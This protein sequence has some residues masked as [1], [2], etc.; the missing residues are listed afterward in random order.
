[1][2]TV[3]G[4]RLLRVKCKIPMLASVSDDQFIVLRGLLSDN[5]KDIMASPSN[6]QALN[7][8]AVSALMD[9]RLHHPKFVQHCFEA[10]YIPVCNVDC[11]RGFSA[12]GDIL[13]PNRN[14][15]STFNTEVLMCMYFGY[16]DDLNN[17]V[18]SSSSNSNS[19]SESFMNFDEPASLRV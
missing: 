19:N 5:V 3:S 2:G 4:D 9:M 6:Y 14:R 16:G 11:E 15:L 13:S 18:L 12:Y 7:D 10:L 17:N 8:P 1:M